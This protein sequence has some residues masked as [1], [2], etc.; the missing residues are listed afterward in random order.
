MTVQWLQINEVARVLANWPD[1]VCDPAL[2]IR[3]FVR[4]VAP[5]VSEKVA[6]NSLCYYK[7]GSPYGVIGGN[8]CAIGVRHDILILGFLHGAA[9]PD[10]EGILQGTGKAKRDI[11]I[12]TAADFRSRR[13]AI[14]KLIRAAIDHTPSG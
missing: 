14:E 5:E 11:E 3:E 2:E 12:K 6:F 4:E 7:A 10:P 1:E 13:T 8:V 9:L